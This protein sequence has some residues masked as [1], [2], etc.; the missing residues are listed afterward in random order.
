MMVVALRV[1][2]FES[3]V[4]LAKAKLTWLIVL[5][6]RRSAVKTKTVKFT[7]DGWHWHLL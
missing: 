4:C 1:K 2:R 7:S 6:N 5:R 3:Y